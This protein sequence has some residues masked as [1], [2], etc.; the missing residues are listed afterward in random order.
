MGGG[1]PRGGPKTGVGSFQLEFEV[2]TVQETL[3]NT[4]FGYLRPSFFRELALN[5]CAN[6]FSIQSSWLEKNRCRL[7]GWTWLAGGGG[8]LGSL[9]LEKNLAERECQ[10]FGGPRR[11][12]NLVSLCRGPKTQKKLAPP[13][14][15]LTPENGDDQ[16]TEG[17]HVTSSSQTA[18]AKPWKTEK[19]E[20]WAVKYY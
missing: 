14:R 17:W 16:H 6:T 3:K 5:L 11:N 12:K 13:A 9:R 18:D 1:G 20:I 4:I 15:A 7:A 2:K 10:N 19:W 8:G